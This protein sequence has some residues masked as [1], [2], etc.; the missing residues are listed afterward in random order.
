MSTRDILN[1]A[2]Q[3]MRDNG[4]PRVPEVREA[5][6]RWLTTPEWQLCAEL[7]AKRREAPALRLIQGG[8]PGVLP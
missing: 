7:K 5:L 6:E 2:V 3:R 4:G 1:Y 8:K